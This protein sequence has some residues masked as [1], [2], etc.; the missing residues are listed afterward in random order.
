VVSGT[1]ADASA[2]DSTLNVYFLNMPITDG[3]MLL[4]STVAAGAVVE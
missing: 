3:E 1:A 4:L 2:R